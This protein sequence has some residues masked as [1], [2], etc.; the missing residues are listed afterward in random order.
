MRDESISPNKKIANFLLMYRNAPR[1]TTNETPAKLFLGRNLR[2]RVDLIRPDNPI[3]S[4]QIGGE[5]LYM[6]SI[7][8]LTTLLR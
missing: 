6:Q 3:V 7:G 5:L 8:L 1:S 2:S 4:R